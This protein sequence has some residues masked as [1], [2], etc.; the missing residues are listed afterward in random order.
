MAVKPRVGLVVP[1]LTECGGVTSVAR[2]LRDV[3]LNSGCFDLKMISLC[4]DSRDTASVR[5]LQPKT[6]SRGIIAESADWEG[7]PY[8][9]VG[10]CFSELEFQRYKPNPVL[11]DQLADVD[12]IQVVAGSAACANAVTGL[13]KPVSLQVATRARVERRR[14]D[15]SPRSASGWW[16]RAMTEITDR[17][18]DR[19]L[20]NC[21]A[22]L[23]ENQWMYEY[24]QRLNKNRPVDLRYAPPGVDSDVFCPAPERHLARDPYI[25]AIGRLGDRRKNLELLGRSFVAIAERGDTRTRLILAGKSGPPAGFWQIID[26]AGLRHRVNYLPNVSQAEIVNLYQQAN[27]FALP[28]DEEGLGIVLLEAMACGIPVVSTRCGG[29]D[30]VI[31]HGVDGF[32]VPL[33][34]PDA[35]ARDLAHLLSDIDINKSL[36]RAARQRIE[37]TFSVCATASEFVDTWKRLFEERCTALN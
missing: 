9:R 23:V 13:G 37:A 35:M 16:R 6:W 25:L 12:V 19:A 5:L 8:I 3:A 28:S 15:A 21:D 10:A 2:F 32:L 18:D 22:I 30:G 20:L 31:R 33:N 36:G 11:S 17:Y 26:Q 24:A 27:A 29:P 4:M 14:R 34:D 1:S 7:F